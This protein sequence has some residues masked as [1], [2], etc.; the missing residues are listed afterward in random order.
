MTSVW[1]RRPPSWSAFI[2]RIR[3][4][5]NELEDCGRTSA[6]CLATRSSFRSKTFSII[7]T[8][9]KLT[10]PIFEDF[11]LILFL[12][13]FLSGRWFDSDYFL[14]DDPLN[15][16]QLSVHTQGTPIEAKYIDEMK[17]KTGSNKHREDGFTVRI[18]NLIAADLN[19]SIGDWHSEYVGFNKSKLYHQAALLLSNMY[20][21][22]LKS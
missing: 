1:S 18:D 20:K 19:C 6:L 15:S 2:R 17:R 22:K 13:K 7:S 9:G 11:Q 10:W 12:S 8:I 14:L 5:W 4:V 16:V 3:S 21:N